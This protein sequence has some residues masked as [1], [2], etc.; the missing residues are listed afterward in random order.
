[1]WEF[2]LCIC[3]PDFDTLKK[4]NLVYKCLEVGMMLHSV[5]C[6]SVHRKLLMLYKSMERNEGHDYAD[7]INV[8]FWSAAGE[9]N[10]ATYK[11]Y[12]YKTPMSV[13]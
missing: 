13:L 6:N 5:I 2:N 12:S 4:C 11:L 9:I 7:I 1:M 3:V 8:S 10:T